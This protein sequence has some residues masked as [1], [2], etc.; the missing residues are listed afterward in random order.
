[1]VDLSKLQSFEQLWACLE[2]A[3]VSPPLLDLGAGLLSQGCMLRLCYCD[4]DGDWL[5]ITP[6]ESWPVFAAAARKLLIAGRC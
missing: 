1:M 3:F 4:I 6:D 5:T 2:A